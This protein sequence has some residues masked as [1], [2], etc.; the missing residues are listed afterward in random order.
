MIHAMWAV[1]RNHAEKRVNRVSMRY[2]AKEMVV[3]AEG[4]YYHLL[5]IFV[6]RTG[7][8][9]S[10]SRFDYW[11]AVCAAPG[12]GRPFRL[13]IPRRREGLPA[14]GAG[15]AERGPAR[16]E[17]SPKLGPEAGRGWSGEGVSGGG[18]VGAAPLFR[19]PCVR[20]VAFQQRF[21]TGAC[22]VTRHATP[23]LSRRNARRQ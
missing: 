16:P 18:L 8:W 6:L 7:I 22:V 9:A 11:N 2:A 23:R 14:S 13:P 19:A 5:Y 21:G 4:F 12:V 3:V 15:R 20:L 17:T 10:H 1:P